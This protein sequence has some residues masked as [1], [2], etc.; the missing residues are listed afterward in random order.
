M[1]TNV[2]KGHFAVYIGESKKKRFVVPISFLS[3]PSFQGLPS[4]AEEE[5]GF[6][7]PMGGLTIPC[8]E[9]AFINLICHLNSWSKDII[10]KNIIASQVDM[11]RWRGKNV[12]L[13][14]DILHYNYEAAV[15]IKL[16]RDK[17]NGIL[18]SY[19]RKDHLFDEQYVYFICKGAWR[20]F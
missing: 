8:N 16:S 11:F 14:I 19:E 3:H 10:Q 6:N 5:F 18:M 20:K 2:R 13:L 1:A 15:L 4:Q 12:V 9:D 17:Y 7:H